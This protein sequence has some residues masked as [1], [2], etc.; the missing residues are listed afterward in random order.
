LDANRDVRLTL[1]SPQALDD[2]IELAKWLRG[3]R[4]LQ[5]HVSLSHREPGEQDLGASL[6][7]VSV[8]VSSG[9]LATVLASSLVTWL[10]SRRRTTRIKLTVTR[11]DSS[12]E[13]ETDDLEKAEALIQRFLGV[14]DGE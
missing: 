5:G 4:F 11:A 10:Q 7:F 3:E 12:L 14:P 13:I 8:A 1:D 2:T 9:G 6:D